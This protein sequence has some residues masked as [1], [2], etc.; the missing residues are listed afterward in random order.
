MVKAAV[1]FMNSTGSPAV[2]VGALDD[3]GDVSG[4]AGFCS[5][6]VLKSRVN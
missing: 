3:D 6:M 1:G 4:S 5:Q 2:V